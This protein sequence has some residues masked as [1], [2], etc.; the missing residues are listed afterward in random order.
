MLAV[1]GHMFNCL[2][3]Q[4]NSC[5]KSSLI[6]LIVQTHFKYYV[7]LCYFAFQFQMQICQISQKHF[8]LFVQPSCNVTRILVK[9]NKQCLSG[10][11]ITLFP[12]K[13]KKKRTW[14]GLKY[15]MPALP[16]S[17]LARPAFRNPQSQRPGR[18]DGTRCALGGRE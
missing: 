15:C 11:A 10:P 14:E 5:N 7:I 12:Q 8:P 16:W 6:I 1:T 4:Q 2:L 13:E 3:Q 17:L 9:A 18:K